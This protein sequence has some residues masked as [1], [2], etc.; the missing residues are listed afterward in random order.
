MKTL[1]IM[2]ISLLPTF[3]FG[4]LQQ[5]HAE[6]LLV[7]DNSVRAVFTPPS[8]WKDA[9][10]QTMTIDEAVIYFRQLKIWRD[11]GQL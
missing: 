6:A 9:E 11:G 2:I 3:A 4:D 1:L 10:V 8:Y 5:L 7:K